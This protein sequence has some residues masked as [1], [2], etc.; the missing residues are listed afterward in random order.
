MLGGNIRKYRK[1]HNMSQEDLADKLAVS[2]QTISLWE[3]NQTQPSIENVIILS[4]LFGI[5]LD[6]LLKEAPAESDACITEEISNAENQLRTET[7][8][9]K[10][11]FKKGVIIPIVL[12]VALMLIAGSVIALCH[13]AEKDNSEKQD[14]QP[15]TTTAEVLSAEEIYKLLAESTVEIEATG[16]AFTSTGSGMFIDKIGTVVTNYHVIESCYEIKVKTYD[17][18][19]IAVNSIKGYSEG[20]D[21]AILSTSKAGSI[22]VQMRTEAVRTGE[23]IYTLGSSLGLT[24]TFSEGIVSSNLR[25]IEGTE[26]IQITAPISSGNSGGPLVDEYGKVV[27]ITSA[28]IS[29]GQ[30]LNLAIPIAKIN[31]VDESLN[32]AVFDFYQLTQGKVQATPETSDPENTPEEEYEPPY[33]GEF[34]SL[35]ELD[36]MVKRNPAQFNHPVVVSI[37][38]YIAR[39]EKDEI[40][41]LNCGNLF[42][43]ELPSFER[44]ETQKL[45]MQNKVDKAIS[46]SELKSRVYMVDDTQNRVLSGDI[47]IITGVYRHDIKTLSEC[48]YEYLG[49]VFDD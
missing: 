26:Y 20:L 31:Q 7:P 33:L 9:Q 13:Y 46:F 2:R 3:N 11:Q 37:A 5:S 49:S 19:E 36:N 39:N 22:P 28:G 48:V 12:A 1:E 45:L 29:E 34:T 21:L 27:G 4:K 38:G 25:E 18:T 17:G 23:K 16:D 44:L 8:T 24:G 40:Y 14:T 41:L 15:Q 35:E 47:V 32:L 10:M 42:S 30:N 43:S 6:E